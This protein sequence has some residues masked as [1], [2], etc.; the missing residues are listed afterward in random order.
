MF[1]LSNHTFHW[2]GSFL[3]FFRFSMALWSITMSKCLLHSKCLNL[4]VLTTS[5]H[6]TNSVICKWLKLLLVIFGMA[7]K[8]RLM[9]VVHLEIHMCLLWL[10][11]LI[12]LDPFILKMWDSMR[13][14]TAMTTVTIVFTRVLTTKKPF[15]ELTAA[16]AKG[17][18]TEAANSKV[19]HTEVAE[20]RTQWFTPYSFSKWSWMSSLPQMR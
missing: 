9:L 16:L 8:I 17:G 5:S 4:H 11:P 19:T 7:C 3:P 12:P 1:Q 20:K 13:D 6:S 15:P 14:L 10:S 2:E 18:L